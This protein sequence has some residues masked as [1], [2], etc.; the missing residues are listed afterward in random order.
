[1]SS[2]RPTVGEERWLAVAAR[3]RGTVDPSVIAGRTGGWRVTGPLARIALFVLG[4]L[5]AVL[6]AAVLGF[7]GPG[8]LAASGFAA[9]AAAELLIRSRRLHA[10]GVEEGLWTAGAAMLAGWVYW[11]AVPHDGS[12]DRMRLELGIAVAL[13]C[14]GLRLGNG[15]VT[16]AGVVVA[17]AWLNG[18]LTRSG[19]MAGGSWSQLAL[20]TGVAVL[21]LAAG[22][23]GRVRPSHDRTLDWLAAVVVPATWLWSGVSPWGPSDRPAYT[24]LVVTA[25]LLAYGLAS[26]TAGVRRRRHAPLAGGLVAI[27]C[28]A[29]EAGTLSTLPI[30]AQMILGGAAA[31]GA[32]L[33]L[34]HWLRVP[35]RGITSRSQDDAE[36]LELLQSAGTA[37]LTARVAPPTEA[38]GATDPRGGHFGG[39]GAS[40]GY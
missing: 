16:T 28:A 32:G 9:L 14:A 40:G 34:E 39:G 8:T 2:G 3:L 15:F 19:L 24:P 22:A 10:S 23:R 18:T 29:V 35:R 5:A 37:I 17:I 36:A 11:Q 33:V 7:G 12:V 26:I 25:V 4:V 20:G 30:E 31:L 1:M 21:A 27:A 38:P 13:A 6:L